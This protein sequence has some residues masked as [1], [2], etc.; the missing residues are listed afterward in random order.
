[1]NKPKVI[2]EVARGEWDDFVTYGYYT[3]KIH[4]DEIAHVV[5]ALVFE[6]ELDVEPEEY[7]KFKNKQ[8]SEGKQ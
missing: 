4:A 2:Y 3:D 8:E 6:R 5:D 1:M 7:K